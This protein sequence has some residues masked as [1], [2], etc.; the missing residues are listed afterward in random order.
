MWHAQAQI[1]RMWYPKALNS[2]SLAPEVKH[3]TPTIAEHG[4]D[5]RMKKR[6]WLFW[7]LVQ[8]LQSLSR[9]EKWET[10]SKMSASKEGLTWETL[11]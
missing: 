1:A 3:V 6:E 7:Q 4:W 5:A 2:E 9:F 8:G 11:V 10:C